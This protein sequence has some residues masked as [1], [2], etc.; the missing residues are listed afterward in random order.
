MVLFVSRTCHSYI[1]AT[2]IL[3][4]STRVP[5]KQLLLNLPRYL[6]KYRVDLFKK[7][8]SRFVESVRLSMKPLF[9]ATSIVMGVK[10]FGPVPSFKASM[11]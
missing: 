7:T 10:D 9:S 8:S 6:C 2:T 3:K 5:P 4:K 1:Q 11:C